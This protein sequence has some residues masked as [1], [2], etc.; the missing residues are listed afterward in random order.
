MHKAFPIEGQPLPLTRRL[1]PKAVFTTMCKDAENGVPFVLYI[2][3]CFAPEVQQGI[4]TVA[5]YA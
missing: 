2:A 3:L 5:I 4:G 1:L